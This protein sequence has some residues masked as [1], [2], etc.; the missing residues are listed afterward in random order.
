MQKPVFLDSEQDILR[1][2]QNAN[3]FNVSS[4]NQFQKTLSGSGFAIKFVTQGIENY[5]IEKRHY[6]LGAGSYLLTNGEKKAQVLIDSNTNVKGI[7]VNLDEE[8][9]R[10]TVASICEG[11]S[12]QPDE[13]VSK[14]FE[15]D[16]FFEN[17]YHS[18]TTLLGNHLEKIKTAI[19]S[20]EFQSSDINEELFF[21]LAL[22]LV[23][24][25]TAVYKQLQNVRVVK[26]HTQRE[27]FR[28][29][30]KGKLFMD[31]HFTG[32]FQI[33]DFAKEA[34]ISDFHFFRLFKTTFGLTPYQYIL[35]KRL[36]KAYLD[37]KRGK[38]ISDAAI[39]C[40]FADVF[41]FSKAF[42]KHFGITPGQ[43]K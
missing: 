12:A 25:Q 8:I 32:E 9:I 1:F 13:N 10:K 41:S 14:F 19:K 36:Q 40:G 4:L 21:Q 27:L 20:G 33:A 39:E 26:A 6:Q 22:N 35:Q 37:L 23:K 17:H 38:S 42:K 24:D 30:S 16:H 7:C 11:D 5:A 18:G 28:R 2:G 15:Q 3:T 43:C 34:A 29:L 31:T